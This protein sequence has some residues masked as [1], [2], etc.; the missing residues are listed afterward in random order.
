MTWAIR[1]STTSRRETS[2]TGQRC[3]RTVSLRVLT[4]ALNMWH[5]WRYRWT[6]S[7]SDR[8]KEALK[9]RLLITRFSIRSHRGLNQPRN[10]AFAQALRTHQRTDGQ[11]DSLIEM[12]S[13]RTH[14]KTVEGS[15]DMTASGRFW[16][17]RRSWAGMAHDRLICSFDEA[18]L[19][20]NTWVFNGK[21]SSKGAFW[22][23][24]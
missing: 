16:K 11:T 3:V 9:T 1:Q 7:W 22:V 20:N 6:D 17:V 2:P 21:T 24:H 13:W 8:V 5:I 23:S 12:R 19:N 10:A 4:L 15:L 18:W 14:L